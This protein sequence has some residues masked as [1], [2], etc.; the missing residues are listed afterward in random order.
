M[1]REQQ[2][3]PGQ[4]QCPRCGRWVD[5][6]WR[7]VGD[8]VAL[9]ADCIRPRRIQRQQERRRLEETSTAGDRL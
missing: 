3:R 9:C 4:V 5:C 6:R 8:D 7:I 1:P 2:P